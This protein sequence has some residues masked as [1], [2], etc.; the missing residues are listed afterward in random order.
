MIF[1][2]QM[3]K[4]CNLTEETATVSTLNMA[5]VISP[6]RVIL[7]SARLRQE[8]RE[9]EQPV[10]FRALVRCCFKIQK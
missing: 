8:G 2:I 1:Q 3:R 6:T 4:L 9:F 7:H 5:I 10:Q